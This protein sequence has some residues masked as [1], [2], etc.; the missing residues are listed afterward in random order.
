MKSRRCA[1]HAYRETDF[2][3]RFLQVFPKQCNYDLIKVYGSSQIGA[4]GGGEEI[5]RGI[6]SDL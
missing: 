2:N 4:K 3:A 1:Y 6:F 5:A